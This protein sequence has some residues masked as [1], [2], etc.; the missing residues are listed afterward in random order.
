MYIT[1]NMQA[2]LKK[3]N[4]ST[5]LKNIHNSKGELQIK[6]TVLSIVDICQN[7]ILSALLLYL[8]L[9]FLLFFRYI[10]TRGR[11]GKQSV[12]QSPRQQ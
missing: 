8:Y 6:T 4:L 12:Q 1:S 5:L 9:I 3:Y 7:I 10:Q 11:D 2:F